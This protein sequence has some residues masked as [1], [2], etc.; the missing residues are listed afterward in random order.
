MQRHGGLR[1]AAVFVAGRAA[2][3]HQ[4]G[5]HALQVPLEGAADGLVEVV[6]VEDQPAVGR[7]IGAQVAHMGVAAELA[8][9]A[10]GG[11]LAPGR[12]PSPAPRRESSRR[13]TRPS[14][15]IS[16][17]R[18]PARGRASSAP[19]DRAASVCRA[20]SSSASCWWRP[21]CLRRAWPSARRSSGVAQ[22]IS[23]EHTPSGSSA[24]HA[25]GVIY[26][27]LEALP[28]LREMRMHDL[29]RGNRTVSRSSVSHDSVPVRCEDC[30]HLSIGKL[31][32]CSRSASGGTSCCTAFSCRFR[33]LL[34][35]AS[36]RGTGAGSQL[37]VEAIFAH[38]PLIRQAAR[39]ARPGLPTAST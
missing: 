26:T 3:Q 7:G 10:G 20:L 38:G 12:R 33:C 31:P 14:A 28:A 39:A 25:S 15:G 2:G 1:A 18:A 5:G 29:V 9:D 24:Q 11:Q 6:D 22:C 19:A 8:H 36:A 37:T 13:A 27:F 23:A 16:A 4:R 21:T 32:G 34:G 30:P 35:F 17:R